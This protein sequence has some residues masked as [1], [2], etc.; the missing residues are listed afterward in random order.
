MT[1]SLPLSP[2]DFEWIGTVAAFCTTA[3]FVPQLIR[4]WK[5]KSA[6]DISLWMFL[7]FNLG[8]VCWLVYGVGIGSP[9]VIAANAVTLVLALTILAL[10]LKFDGS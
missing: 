4:V 3:A 8:L 2:R 10:K 1:E 7:L 5:R 9:P 6:R